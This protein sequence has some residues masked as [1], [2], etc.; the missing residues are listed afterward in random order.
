MIK[1][2]HFPERKCQ[3]KPVCF[4]HRGNMFPQKQASLSQV[5]HYRAGVI[6]AVMI[7]HISVS[8]LYMRASCVVTVLSLPH[9]WFYY[10][11][12][13]NRKKQ[14]VCLRGLPWSCH[15][16]RSGNLDLSHWCFLVFD[17]CFLLLYRPVSQFLWR[18]LCF[19]FLLCD[20]SRDAFQVYGWFIRYRFLVYSSLLSCR[21]SLFPLPK[22]FIVFSFYCFA[23]GYFTFCF[24][25]LDEASFCLFGPV[26]FDFLIKQVVKCA[27]K[28][29][30]AFSHTHKLMPCVWLT[31][32]TEQLNRCT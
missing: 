4:H 9:L 19:L 20:L 11:F 10:M 24:L 22:S 17:S 23:F 14:A 12:T 3:S 2:D 32:V 28:R 13:V 27:L 25:V 5:S 30:R 1:Q 15:F 8:F 31:F 21:F 18:H 7:E 29:K 6:P 26:K 16:Q